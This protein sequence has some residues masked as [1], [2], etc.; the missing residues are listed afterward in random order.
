MIEDTLNSPRRTGVPMHMVQS[1]VV[2]AWRKLRPERSESCAIEILK[3]WK[4]KKI[5]C[6]LA[7]VGPSGS[8]VV[9]K[10]Y[11]MAKGMIERTIYMDVLADLP[12]PTLQCYGLV[13]VADGTCWLF[14]EDA[15]EERYS[16]HMAA[17]RALAGRWLGILH[18]FTARITAPPDLPNRGPNYYLE[19]LRRARKKILAGR[20]NPT[21]T[22]DDLAVLD[23]ILSR[24]DLLEAR[25]DL[26][27]KICDSMP[28]TVVH[29][30]FVKKNMRLRTTSAGFAL[31]P[32]DWGNAGWGVPAVDLAQT[33]ARSSRFSADPDLS[34][35]WAEVRDYW[36]GCDLDTI[37]RWA[38]AGSVFRS[39]ASLYWSALN[40]PF[41]WAKDH[42]AK[43]RVDH[44][45]I[46][47]VIA[48]A[49]LGD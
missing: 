37:R 49:G 14:L 12:V 25:W 45:V 18:T 20:V 26:L 23:M 40:L 44:A 10:R 39:V 36:S 35:Y 27:E 47:R 34:E 38:N 32:F 17:H 28:R 16:P 7:G 2:E 48:A 22:A 30:D 6:R 33:L 24:L 42:V 29:G 21:L 1:Q 9:A 46:A 8:A 11:R 5:V 4:E 31:M 13:A 41:E 3:G 19:C 43:M 15:G